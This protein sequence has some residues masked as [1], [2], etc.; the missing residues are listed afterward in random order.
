MANLTQKK[1][2]VP[3]GADLFLSGL[4][5]LFAVIVLSSCAGTLQPLPA[6]TP[7]PN[8]L[9][10]YRNADF[11]IA[12]APESKKLIMDED[13]IDAFNHHLMASN[14][15]LKDIFDYPD[16]MEA[17]YLNLKF[18]QTREVLEKKQFY[19][20]RGEPLEKPY[21]DALYKNIGVPEDK[22]HVL[23]GIIIRGTNV[24]LVPADDLALKKNTSDQAF[25]RF[26]VARLDIGTPVAV[27]HASVDGNWFFIESYS[28]SG[29]VNSKDL[30]VAE[31]AKVQY[32]EAV[33]PLV[34]TGVS[35]PFYYDRDLK[36]F[37]ANYD[38]GTALPYLLTHDDVHEVVLPCREPDGSLY[39]HTGYTRIDADVSTDYLDYTLANV[40]RQAFKMLGMAY[41]WGSRLDGTEDCSGFIMSVFSCFG[42]DIPRNSLSQEKVNESRRINLAGLDKAGK[43]EILKKVEGR[44]VL[45]YKKGHIMLYLGTVNGRPYAI[46]SMWSYRENEDGRERERL[47]KRVA[48]SDLTAGEGTKEGSYLDRLV[49]V[50]PLD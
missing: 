43:M 28:V 25:D 49:S 36:K 7:L 38:L 46:H 47:V 40:Y 42:L 23:F 3:F 50:I 33:R 5:S 45:L 21:L 9:P 15:R 20:A 19:S 18:A 24:R 6:P 48:V 41:V 4:I 29:W 44:P 14:P 39:Y 17:A 35:V 13:G 27:M 31:K 2:S 1:R 11:W 16:M 8:V 30:A 12:R 34:A 37:A 32:F 10:E 26:Q 22:H